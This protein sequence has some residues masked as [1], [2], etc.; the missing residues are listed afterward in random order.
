MSGNTPGSPVPRGEDPVR[1]YYNEHA[2]HEWLRLED[3]RVEFAITMRALEEYLPAAPRRVLDIGGGPGRYSI[4]LARRGYDVTL[5]DFSANELAIARSRASEADVNIESVECDARDLSRFGD[6]SFDVVLMMGP[7]YHL[8]DA[9]DR[10]K[11]ISEAK[12]VLVPGGRFFA[13]YITRTAVLRFWAKYDP[14]RVAGD[15]VRYESHLD[16][17][18]VRDNFGFTDVYLAHP[19]KI[20]PAM[21]DAGFTT[22][23]L[24]GC[25]G[26]ISM[27]REKVNELAGDA[28]ET[29]IDLNYRLAKDPSNHG[30]SEHLLYVGETRELPTV[31]RGETLR[32][33]QDDGRPRPGNGL[34]RR[35]PDR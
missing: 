17:G 30:G 34:F 10:A 23:D 8:L 25:E 31:H 24:I 15:R 22:L 20:A 21:E 1:H 7:L 35:R 4:E 5:A 18:E 3:D 19:T 32:F 6:R 27:I 12:R 29:W 26:V 9:G 13:V 16:T 14:T 33:A 11:A 28:W 2:E